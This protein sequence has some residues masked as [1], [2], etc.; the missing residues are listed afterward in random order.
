M[1][2][3]AS[4]QGSRDSE[5]HKNG[6]N[7][8]SAIS[9]T[10][11][12]KESPED[13]MV[14]QHRLCSVC[15]SLVNESNILNGRPQIVKASDYQESDENIESDDESDCGARR[16][17]F[18]HHAGMEKLRDSALKECH[19]C[20]KMLDILNHGL[21]EGIYEIDTQSLD[22]PEPE[23]KADELKRMYGTHPAIWQ[24]LLHQHER[25]RKNHLARQ[26]RAQL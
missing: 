17:Q 11:K 2:R 16:E 14:E 1:K 24:H 8:A 6:S 12:S 3:R 7:A 15:R 19:L 25:R 21:Q 26:R 10:K 9:D 23:S 20:V 5:R 18:L 22:E 4:F 13:A